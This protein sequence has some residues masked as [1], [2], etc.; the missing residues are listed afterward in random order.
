MKNHY[1]C[2]KSRNG[3]YGTCALNF[4]LN[5]KIRLA[6]THQFYLKMS[7]GGREEVGSCISF[8]GRL[9]TDKLQS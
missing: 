8:L 3:Q 7:L 1:M 6:E 5:L 4:F 2:L 9:S